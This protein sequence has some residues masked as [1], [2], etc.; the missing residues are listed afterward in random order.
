MAFGYR[1]G[2]MESQ[3]GPHQPKTIDSETVYEC[4][5]FAVVRDTV[6]SHRG[7]SYRIEYVTEEPAV[8]IY[9]F[10]S[11]GEVVVVDEWRQAVGRVN[12]GLPAGSMEADEDIE[13]AAERELREE[14]GFEPAEVEHVRSVE[15]T[16]GLSD[17][18][19][20]HVVAFGC[21]P[22][23][24]QDL[25]TDE[26]IVPDT[27]PEAALREALK[28]GDLRDGRTALAVAARAFRNP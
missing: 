23:A 12:R 17:S 3:D 20:H 9:P 16:N 1:H 4:D 24:G 2:I 10:T 6:R 19:H 25:D 14:T 21:T 27:V 13:T 11:D 28:S 18:V 26:R 7:E 5:D 22:T 15:P 8:V